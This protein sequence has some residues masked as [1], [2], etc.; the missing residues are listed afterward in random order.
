MSKLF[1]ASV[2]ENRQLTKNHY[3]ITLHPLE[4]NAKPKPGQFFMLSVNLGADP[5]LRRP[6]SLHRWLG[7]D[8]QILYK[9]LGKLTHILKDKKNHDT[10]EIIGPLGNG[11]PTIK[12]KDKPIFAGGG[13]GVV[14]LFALAETITG[15]NPPFFL[16][17]KSRKEALC[18]DK[19]KSIGIDPVV[20]TDDGTLGQK[21]LIT[22]VLR[23]FLSRHS[24][25][26]T[27]YCLYACGPKPML[28]ELSLLAKKFKLKGYIALEENMA[29]GIGA[30][31]SCVVN[32][33]KGF[34]RVCK[35]GPVFPI[36]EIVW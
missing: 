20:S 26:V 5:L 19:L 10:L 32:T 27:G 1:Q 18:I 34:K 9:V 13:L 22:D 31:L 12:T 21:G 33:K 14:S 35:E 8:F 30:C 29:C 2:K 25:P 3:L 7:Q 24:L 36:E 16:G 28:K 4:K 11:F 23:A 17:A 15:K 6:F